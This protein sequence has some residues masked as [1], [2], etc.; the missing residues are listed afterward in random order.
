MLMLLGLPLQTGCYQFTRV[1]LEG[2][3]VGR[4]V[5]VHLSEAGYLRLADEVGEFVPHLGHTVEGDLVQADE[6]QLLVAVPSRPDAAT[7]GVGFHQRVAI[8]LSDVVGIELKEFNKGRVALITVSAGA[9]LVAF[10]VYYVS[11]EFGGTTAPF[12]EPAPEFMPRH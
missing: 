11:G 4:E 12:P 2:A 8:P 9:A 1:P 6:Q 5:R 7:G 10:I 3:P